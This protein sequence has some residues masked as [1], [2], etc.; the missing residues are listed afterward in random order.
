VSVKTVMSETQ[1]NTP[2]NSGGAPPSDGHKT[3]SAIVGATAV[4][5]VA[6]VFDPSIALTTVTAY[7]AF[8]V[9]LVMGKV[10]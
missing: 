3:E 5:I 6:T 7:F 8:L 2:A 4:T 10:L 9:G 1:A